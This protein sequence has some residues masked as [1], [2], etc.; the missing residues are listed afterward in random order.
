MICVEVLM[1]SFFPEQQTKE[2][3]NM[4]SQYET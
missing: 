2:R 4:Q 1:H 3:N